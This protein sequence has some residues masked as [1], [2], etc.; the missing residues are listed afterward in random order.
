MAESIF[1]IQKKAEEGDAT[2]QHEMGVNYQYGYGVPV[3]KQKSLKWFLKAAENGNADSMRALGIIYESGS[4]VEQDLRKAFEY[5]ERAVKA[6]NLKSLQNLA[7]YYKDGI[8]VERNLDKARDLLESF[9]IRLE[10]SALENDPDAMFRL[11][12]FY[13]NGCELLGIPV[14][15]QQAAKWYEKA[16]DLGNMYAQNSL[17][18]LCYLGIGVPKNYR[19]AAQL[20]QK[21]ADQGDAT[22]LYNLAGC[23]RLGRGVEQ[24]DEQAA[25][26]NQQAAN[27]DMAEAQSELAGMYYRGSGVEQDYNM[28]VYWYKR[29]IANGYAN[30]YYGLG[31]CYYGGKGVEKDFQEAFRLFEVGAKRGDRLCL[32]AVAECCIDGIGTAPDHARAR[33]ILE[34]ICNE[35]ED[36]QENSRFDAIEH[37]SDD[38][39]FWYNPLD[40]HVCSYYAKAHYLLGKLIYADK[41]EEGDSP[42]KAIA[43]LRM[44][45]KLGYADDGVPPKELISQIVEE[46][47]RNSTSDATDCYVE[48][49]ENKGKGERFLVVLHHADG[50]ESVVSFKGRNKF[51][52]ILALL[53]AY[54]GKS[55]Y[56]LTTSHFSYM[57]DDL[58]QMAEDSCVNTDNYAEWIDEFVYAEKP[59]AQSMRRQEDM[60]TMGYC[61]LNAYRY[62]NAFSGANRAI[63]ASCI[64]ADEYEIFRLRSTGGR[65]AITTMSME[66]SQIEIPTSLQSYLNCLPTQKELSD[67]RPK[68]AKWLPVKE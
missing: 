7:D 63:K 59:E 14:N 40:E 24:D 58:T 32:E 21:A 13:Q 9:F 23:Y 17:G 42:S 44:A 52:Y 31:C 39:S 27:M 36:N 51:V 55:V 34:A 25:A 53:I 6:G 64:S 47:E 26:C 15:L 56:G 33:R 35:N 49:R 22:A 4:G 30:A 57:R 12:D 38:M 19:K 10:K 18:I 2:C 28:A 1:I 5:F 16:A 20:Y 8:V 48:V 45:E 46:T 54:E 11:G 41:D 50:T 61:S 68:Q 60:E 67:Y 29:A 3:S 37:E 66:P 43:Y 62:S 65:S